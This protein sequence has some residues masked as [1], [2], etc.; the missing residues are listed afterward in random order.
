MSSLPERLGVSPGQ[1]WLAVAGGLTVVLAAG[2]LLFPETVYD[3]FLWHYFWGP[4]QADAHNAVCAVRPGST[5][6]YLYSASECAAAAEPVAEPGYTLVSEAGYVVALLIT[7][8]GTVLMLDNFG[9]GEEPRFFWAMVPFMLLGSGLRVIED[10][11]NQMPDGGGLSYPLN[12]L[13]I[14]PVIYFTVF[15]IAVACIL[16]AIWLNRQGHTDT[17]HRPLT[18]MGTVVFLL[19]LG[20]LSVLAVLPDNPVVFYPQVLAV[21]VAGSVAST[22][23]TWYAIQWAAPHIHA[24]TRDIG[25]M[26]LFAHAVD[27]V[28]N[29]V[30]LDYMELLGAGNNLYPKHPVNKW[31]VETSGFAFPFLVIKMVAAAFVLWIFEP[32]LYEESP[33]YTTLLLVAVTS[34]GL[35]PGTRD[36]FR[37]MFGV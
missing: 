2:S 4:V 1:L 35:G 16:A 19:S 6:E 24:G 29:V 20:Y 23:L 33:R 13:F 32:E 3:G 17:Y 28:A 27:G 22:A 26:V 37:A 14:S 34:V 25:V 18:V 31:V 8:T 5:V 10:A 7:I 12:T 30:G 36:L 21:V 9:V 11:H 15:V